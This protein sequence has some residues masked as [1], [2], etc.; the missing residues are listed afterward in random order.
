MVVQDIFLTKTAEIADVVLPGGG[1]LGRDRGHGHQLGAP[2]AARA[3]GH[4]AARRGARRPVDHLRDRAPDGPR[5]GRGLG[6]GRLERA[7]HALAGARRHEL[8]APR[9]RGR[10]AVAVL[11]RDAP[12]RAVPPLAAV[13]RIRCRATARR[14]CRS[15]TTAPVD[16]LDD[17]FPVRLTTGRHLDSYNTGVQ[18]GGYRSPRRRGETLDLCPED[19]ERFGLAEGEVVRV[20]S[21]RGSVRGARPVRP[22]AAARSRVHDAPLPGRRRRSTSS[23]STPRTRSPARPSSR[24][25][26]SASR[27]SRSRRRAEPA[28]GALA[29]H[30]SPGSPWLSRRTATGVA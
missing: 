30:Q 14:S 11:R 10:A 3:Q 8:R 25:R 16:A 18:S 24:R 21:R 22:V 1:R 20:V 7:A 26:R 4:R 15:S 5:L 12:G 28:R 17:D 13:G 23:R 9:G 19:L 29:P 2:R 27:S 6:R